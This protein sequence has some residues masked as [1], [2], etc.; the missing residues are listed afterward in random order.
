[1]VVRAPDI[2]GPVRTN[3]THSNQSLEERVTALEKR[4]GAQIESGV[5]K[6]TYH[7]TVNGAQKIKGVGKA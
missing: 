2:S 1:M 6:A 3:N 5:L 4:L 7:I